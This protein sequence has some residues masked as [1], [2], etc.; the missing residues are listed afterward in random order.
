MLRSIRYAIQD[1]VFLVG[2]APR[3][4]WRAISSGWTGLSSGVRRAVALAI[5]GVVALALV[6]AVAVPAL[7]CQFPGGDPCAPDDDS[8]D[9]VPAD[10]LAY[11]HV[12]VDPDSDQYE[13]LS[14]VVEDMPGL[15]RQAIGRA[16]ALVPGSAGSP[17]EYEREIRPWFGGQAAVAIVSSGRGVEQVQ[18]LEEGDAGSAR[19]YASSLAAGGTEKDEYLG[20]TLS[21]D[22]RGLT[23]ASVDGFLVIGTSDG[24][25]Q[26]V[27]ASE[28]ADGSRSLGDD[29]LA[30][31]LRDDLP[32]ER[33][34]EAFV[35]QD[36]IDSLIAG[37]RGP[38][39]SLEPF[40]DAG[41][42]RGAA[43]SL[44]IAEG[45]LE[46]AVR[47]SLDP[48][49]SKADPGFFA[50]FPAFEP[51]LVDL[52]GSNSLGYL[53]IGDPGKTVRELISQASAEA[54]AL[55]D[56]FASLVERL[57]ELGEVNIER[58]LLPALGTQAAVGLQ[59]GPEG[60]VPAEQTT[61]AP[62]PTP[63]GL[64]S[65]PGPEVP[66][67][68]PVPVLQF[69]ADGVD[70][71]KARRALANLQGPIADALGSEASLQAPVFDRRE[72]N[73]VE[74][75]T[76]RVS[77]TVNLTYGL[78]DDRLAIATQPSGVEQLISGDGGL[79]RSGI[80]ERATDGFPDEP[81]MLAYLNLSGLINL[82]EREG[83]AEDPAYA[84]YAQEISRLE[85]LGV[86]VDS[87]AEAIETDARLVIGTEDD[88]EPEPATP[89]D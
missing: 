47:S 79:G 71:G 75:Q 13:E 73:G 35:S 25:R 5:A 86:V 3:T 19:R 12:T 37:E 74:V 6:V 77:P 50:A 7:P 14:G 54:P 66:S 2:R 62:A 88:D 87:G 4:G 56:A 42:S 24:V 82:A 49:R 31:D 8:D 72:L 21:T 15:A 22:G 65:G 69:V 78:T 70:T 17:A 11:V 41:A 30:S 45:A 76:L 84:V 18:L 27:D 36:G 60:N 85:A 28:G 61:T 10:S 40:V 1:F 57:R 53:G 63:E 32:P 26:V 89:S 34:A 59:P 81:S 23:T 43:L 29:E 16:L 67:E 52:L 64:E 44:G 80:Y 39:S 83:L 68:P 51:T 20:V 33:F 58:Q 48:E 55:A 9:L 38:L 46:L